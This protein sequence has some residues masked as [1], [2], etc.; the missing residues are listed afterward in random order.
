M[1]RDFKIEIDPEKVFLQGIESNPKP[2]I[3]SNPKP[4][5]ESNPKP[6]IESNP[7]PGIENNPKLGIENPFQ[8]PGPMLLRKV[9]NSPCVQAK[10]FQQS[11]KVIDSETVMDSLLQ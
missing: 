10:I 7:K 8:N 5:I 4:G 2:G 1:H 6:G 11:S 9:V 3:K